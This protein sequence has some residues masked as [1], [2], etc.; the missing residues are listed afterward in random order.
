[1]RIIKKLFEKKQKTPEAPPKPDF[2]KFV[3]T[4][5]KREE[6]PKLIEEIKNNPKKF[7]VAE[8][9]GVKML[10]VNSQET[11]DGRREFYFIKALPKNSKEE[12][13]VGYRTIEVFPKEKEIFL[14]A[15]E[16][17]SGSQPKEI[18]EGNFSGERIGERS[19]L[20]LAD[21]L[22]KQG[23]EGWDIKTI[24]TNRKFA[25]KVLGPVFNAREQGGGWDEFQ[26]KVRPLEDAIKSL[27]QS[28]QK[29]EEQEFK[30]AA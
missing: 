16:V 28:K 30:K 13:I 15:I 1:M 11:R 4:N 19:V 25:E 17:F 26:G 5:M 14:E 18:S 2:G 20:A 8:Y 23:M 29:P 6:Q 12:Q 9:K 10:L 3:G 24:A 7:E 27:E 22:N 21:H